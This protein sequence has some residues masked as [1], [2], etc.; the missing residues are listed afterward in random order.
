MRAFTKGELELL[1]EKAGMAV[2]GIF[3][4]PSLQAEVTDDDWHVGLIARR[5][6]DG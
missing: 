5:L 6:S 1:A 3:S 2:V 4:S